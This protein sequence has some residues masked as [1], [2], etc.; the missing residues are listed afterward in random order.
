MALERVGLVGKEKRR[1]GSLSGGERQRV[2]LAQALIPEPALLVLDEPTS[3]LD[4]GGAG[5]LEQIVQE[6]RELGVTVIWINHDIEQVRRIA[7]KVTGVNQV[8]VLDGVPEEA[9]SSDAST[10]MLQYSGL[11]AGRGTVK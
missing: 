6:Y 2:L 9:L 1:L 8:M 11:Q 3:G 4:V 10:A 5:V 7:D